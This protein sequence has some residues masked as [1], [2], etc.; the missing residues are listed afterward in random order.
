VVEAGTTA[1]AVALMKVL[2]AGAMIQV[3]LEAVRVHRIEIR[4]IRINNM[5]VC[6]AT[7]TKKALSL[8]GL[9]GILHL[10]ANRQHV[11]AAKPAVAL[12]DLQGLNPAQLIS[13]QEKA[14]LP[15]RAALRVAR[16]ADVKGRYTN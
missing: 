14:A 13:L 15:E 2:K 4:E 8:A 5:V 16:V 6:Q 10:P 12:I 7:G 1:V 11:L 3:S 9:P